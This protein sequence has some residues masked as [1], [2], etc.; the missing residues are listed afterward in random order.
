MCNK[1]TSVYI[2]T[3]H[4]VDRANRPNQQTFCCVRCGYQDHADHNAA[5]NLASRW[6]D[7]ELAACQNKGQI[8]A[9]LLKRHE[10]CQQQYG[11]VVVQ[12]PVQLGF[13]DDLQGFSGASTAVG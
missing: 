13:W 6:G 1:V 11:L 5:L 12:P 10:A 7:Q 4:Y 2:T 8:K 3:C 9:L